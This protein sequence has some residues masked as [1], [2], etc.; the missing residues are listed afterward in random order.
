MKNSRFFTVG[1]LEGEPGLA[2]F[3]G[4]AEA[5]PALAFLIFTVEGDTS[6][7]VDNPMNFGDVILVNRTVYMEL[8]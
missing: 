3:A 5:L 7:T 6:S 1:F 2:F 4:E 8:C